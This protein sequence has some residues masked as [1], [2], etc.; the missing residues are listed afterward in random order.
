MSDSFVCQNKDWGLCRRL[1]NGTLRILFLTV[2]RV[3]PVKAKCT[4]GVIKNY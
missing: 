4:R 2:Y 1:R 3:P